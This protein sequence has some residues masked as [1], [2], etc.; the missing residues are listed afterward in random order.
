MTVAGLSFSLKRRGFYVRR[1][2]DLLRLDAR[3]WVSE[4]PPS[5][6]LPL[7]RYALIATTHATTSSAFP[8]RRE[9]D[10]NSSAHFPMPWREARVAQ[11]DFCSSGYQ[12]RLPFPLQGVRCV[13]W[14]DSERPYETGHLPVG[15]VGRLEER[16]SA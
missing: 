15:L 16:D 2:D 6:V 5:G 13:G 11:S 1:L 7:S 9:L 14:I 8:S 10:R 4:R 3:D 12:Y